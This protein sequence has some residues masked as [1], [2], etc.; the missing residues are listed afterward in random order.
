[1]KAEG[2]SGN[3]FITNELG[4]ILSSRNSPRPD[5]V[6]ART[7]SGLFKIGWQLTD[8]HRVGLSL[9][10]QRS[11]RKVNEWSYDLYN[12]WRQGDDRS[13]RLNTNLHHIYTPAAS[14][15][16]SAAET[17]LDMQQTDLAAIGHQGSYQY[18]TGLVMHDETKDRRAKTD[19]KRL[20]IKLEGLP[21]TLWGAEHTLG[22]RAFYSVRDFE[23]LNVDTL[24]IFTNARRGKA[25]DVLTE[26]IQYPVKT[27][28]FGFALKDNIVWSPRFSTQIGLR[29]DHDKTS[30]Q[31]LNAPCSKACT[32]E[33]KPGANSFS[34][35]NAF[36][37]LNA[38]INDNWAASYQISTG[39]RVPT[40]SEMYFTFE[41]PAGSW[42]SNRDLKA[43]RSVNHTFTLVGQ[44]E[45]GRIEASLFRTDYRKFL[46][47]SIRVDRKE[48]MTQAEYENCLLTAWLP[49]MCQRF[50]ES[51][52]MQMVNMNKASITGLE[53]K[54]TLNLHTLADI[55]R[56]WSLNG[57]VGYSR[58]KLSSGESLLSIQPLK[59][60]LGLDYQDPA[61]NFGVFSRLTYLGAKKEKDTRVLDQVYNRRTRS[62]EE[63]MR[64]YQ[65]LNKS[66][67]VFDIYGYWRPIKNLT[68]RAGIYNLFDRKYF[69]WDAMR[70]LDP[71]TPRTTS[72]INFRTG[73]G[74]ERYA[75]PGRSL[76]LSAEYK[77]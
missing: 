25:P 26:T 41:H 61:E 24:N 49:S 51:P 12:R 71:F 36:V 2:T 5:P 60:V 39:H 68:L 59:A 48:L 8:E 58:G 63:Q 43:E 29:Y 66:A 38:A 32:A 73:Q 70:S 31:E 52:V 27:T 1:M 20:Q 53:V 17:E 3:A 37:G 56:G 75:A 6:Q 57:A 9:N 74:L 46:H 14:T 47:E 30:P 34:I 19:Y 10:A 4:Q 35:W 55:P 76:S 69:T 16:L 42:K 21:R 67:F 50:R 22:F 54:G 28:S 44:S 11:S 62:Y 45:T 40:A 33:G 65:Y 72:T 77:F 64:T 18:R 23:T 15:W 7:H 13:E